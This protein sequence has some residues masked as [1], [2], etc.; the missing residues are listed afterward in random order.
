MAVDEKRGTKRIIRG[1]TRLARSAGPDSAVGGVGKSS[2]TLPT[3]SL[4]YSSTSTFEYLMKFLFA[5]GSQKICKTRTQAFAWEN[6]HLTQLSIHFT[7]PV[8]I[9]FILLKF[10]VSKGLTLILPLLRG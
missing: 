10:Y 6:N 1:V 9:L 4:S 3:P 5:F 2:L 8:D 7:G